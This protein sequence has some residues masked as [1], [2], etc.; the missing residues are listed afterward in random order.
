MGCA[1]NR[2]RRSSFAFSTTVYGSLK[3]AM[4]IE[5]VIVSDTAEKPIVYEIA[6]D[7]SPRRYHQQENRGT[8]DSE[9][10]SAPPRDGAVP[11]TVRFSLCSFH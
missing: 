6:V 1:C 9:D 10:R 3:I 11:S 4:R 5:R 7:R 8:R 2:Y